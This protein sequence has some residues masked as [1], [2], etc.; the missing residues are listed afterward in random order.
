MA[1][2]CPPPSLAIDAPR[3]LSERVEYPAAADCAPLPRNLTIRFVDGGPAAGPPTQRTVGSIEGGE[4]AA[5]RCD[6]E[7]PSAGDAVMAARYDVEPLFDPLPLTDARAGRAARGL[8]P[9][10]RL[11]AIGETEL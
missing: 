8:G 10:S 7:N 3:M 11:Q 2:D 4:V 1:Q 6:D 5:A 9:Q